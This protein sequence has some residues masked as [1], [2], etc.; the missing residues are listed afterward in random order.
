MSPAWILGA[1]EPPTLPAAH[2]TPS[3]LP[4][5]RVS[6]A[7]NR[8]LVTERR[9]TKVPTSK[10]EVPP[11]G[12]R[13]VSGVFVRTQRAVVLDT[14]ADAVVCQGSLYRQEHLLT[15]L[16]KP[17]C[18]PCF[19]ESVQPPSVT[20]PILDPVN[21]RRPY[22][23]PRSTLDVAPKPV[24]IPSRSDSAPRQAREH[25]TIP[26]TPRIGDKAIG[27]PGSVRK[28]AARFDSNI[29]HEEGQFRD[30]KQTVAELDRHLGKESG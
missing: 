29:P 2:V 21:R 30:M 7:Q 23:R 17:A 20:L 28:L 14:S 13:H 10:V 1:S 18:M 16:G 12:M 19:D 25:L 11:C 3:S 22:A 4:L 6:P 9:V 26:A 5:G 15:P 8:L 27:T 24:S